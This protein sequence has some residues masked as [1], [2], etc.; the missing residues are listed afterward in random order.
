MIRQSYDRLISTMEFPIPVRHLYIESGPRPPWFTLLTCTRWD[1]TEKNVTAVTFFPAQPQPD[2]RGKNAGQIHKVYVHEIVWFLVYRMDDTRSH[3]SAHNGILV[4]PVRDIW[5][6]KVFAGKEV[7]ALPATRDEEGY[8]GS[9]SANG[10]PIECVG[11]GSRS[12]VS[13]KKTS[14]KSITLTRICVGITIQTEMIMLFS[15]IKNIT[16]QT[17]T[18]DKQNIRDINEYF[19]CENFAVLRPMKK[20]S[21]MWHYGHRLI[22][23][24]L[25][26][27]A[28]STT[29]QSFWK[30]ST[31]E[32]R[33]THVTLSCH[34]HHISRQKTMSVCF[35]QEILLM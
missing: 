10:V 4:C 29:F 25:L 8:C 34:T 33:V 14:V 21:W 16:I 9:V 19:S 30:T 5:Q 11:S 7:I 12:I 17:E 15:S 6:F 22:C 18:Q 13:K 27:R 28:K 26:M 23:I 2:Q 35:K 31:Y 24:I 1:N 32:W 3:L 20:T